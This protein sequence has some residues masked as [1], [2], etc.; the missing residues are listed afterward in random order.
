MARLGTFFRQ[1][2]GETPERFRIR[3]GQPLEEAPQ[4][5]IESQRSYIRRT[6]GRDIGI[7]AYK[8][9]NFTNAFRF[10]IGE[11]FNKPGAPAWGVQQP[12]GAA[13]AQASM[14]F[15]DR[16]PVPTMKGASDMP[17]AKPLF[18]GVADQPVGVGIQDRQIPQASSIR[19]IAEQRLKSVQYGEGAA[20]NSKGEGA[21]RTKGGS[22]F[23]NRFGSGH[24]TF[25]PAQRLASNPSRGYPHD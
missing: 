23:I 22:G 13:F 8:P 15:M 25:A 18:A 7:E 14:N 16:N 2:I 4:S 20:W 17:D 21:W 5:D 24:S 1:R 12:A 3:S 6:E 9:T 10:K 19:A 11:Q